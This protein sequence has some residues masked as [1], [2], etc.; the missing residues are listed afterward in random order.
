MITAYTFSAPTRPDRRQALS[1]S[2]SIWGNAS[3]SLGK[4]LLAILI[5]LSALLT[6]SQAEVE[7]V[8]GG[9]WDDQWPVFLRITKGKEAGTYQVLYLWLENT[10]NEAFSRSAR[11]GRKIGT[12]YQSG[13]LTFSL[14]ETKGLLH[15]AFPKPRMA[16][17]VKIHRGVPKPVDADRVL[18]QFGW[19]AE[20]IPAADALKK[21]TGG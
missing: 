14:D 1:A 9:K 6:S 13:A 11:G 15:G 19:K 5:T 12:Y 7:G 21:I 17:L 8:W 10:E 20:A 3:R 18:E 2:A 4:G 16:N